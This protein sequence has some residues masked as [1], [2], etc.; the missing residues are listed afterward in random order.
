MCRHPLVNA[1]IF[2]PGRE[3]TSL[4]ACWKGTVLVSLH[5]E[6][7]NKQDSTGPA[8]VLC[9]ITEDDM[10]GAAENM[11]RRLS[12]SGL[13]GLDWMLETNTGKPYLIE[14]NLRATQVGHLALWARP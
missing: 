4:V 11:V 5:F 10:Y 7:L 1:Q 9:L 3:A 2:V 6:V 13:H 8:S 12:L 14:M